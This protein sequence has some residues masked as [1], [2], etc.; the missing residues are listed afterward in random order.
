MQGGR[1]NDY[2]SS[3]NEIF[4]SYEVY[5]GHEIGL[6][7]DILTL[8]EATEVIEEVFFECSPIQEDAATMAQS[9]HSDYR[10]DIVA[11]DLGQMFRC[12]TKTDAVKQR[13]AIA[14]TLELVPDA[15]PFKVWLETN[16]DNAEF[17]EMLGL[18]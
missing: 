11:K 8:E 16:R 4:D 5:A 18:R 9:S 7:T 13:D 17:R 2:R 15:K 12:Y 6:V 10:L 3:K 1:W 14:R